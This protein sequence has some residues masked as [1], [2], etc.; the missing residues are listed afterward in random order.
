MDSITST[1]SRFLSLSQ[2]IQLTGL[3]R[4]TIYRRIAVDDFPQP[5]ATGN[6]PNARRI[7][8]ALKDVENWM[9]DRPQAVCARRSQRGAAQFGFVSLVLGAVLL[10]ILGFGAGLFLSDTRPTSRGEHPELVSA[11]AFRASTM[12]VAIAPGK[13]LTSQLGEVQK[14]W[15]ITWPEVRR[16]GAWPLQAVGTPFLSR[17]FQGGVIGFV[18]AGLLPVVIL[19]LILLA[20][21]VMALARQVERFMFPGRT[22]W[23][24]PVR[25]SGRLA[26][27]NFMAVG[28]MG[29]GKSTLLQ[30]LAKH[31]RSLS[32][33]ALIVDYQGEIFSRYFRKSHDVFLSSYDRRSISYSPLAEIHAESDC[34]RVANALVPVSGGSS[35]ERKWA[36]RGRLLVASCLRICFRQ[37]RSGLEVT[38]RSLVQLLNEADAEFFKQNLPESDRLRSV[39]AKDAA[40]FLESVRGVGGFA[41]AAIDGLDPM[42]GFDAFSVRKFVRDSQGTGRW[43]YCVV[44][45]MHEDE[46]FALASFVSAMVVSAKM[47]LGESATRFWMLLDE[48]GQIPA[49]DAI[50]KALSL[51]RKFSLVSAVSFQSIGQLHEHWGEHRSAAIVQGLGNKFLFRSGEPTHLK[52]LVSLVGTEEITRVSTSKSSSFGASPSRSESE[53]SSSR[54]ED[55]VSTSFFK[56]L[57]DWTCV[58]LQ[59]GV[60]GYRAIRVP[61]VDLGRQRF[62]TFVA[63]QN[64]NSAESSRQHSASADDCHNANRDKPDWID[65]DDIVG[66]TSAPSD[67]SSR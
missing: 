53:Q 2:V 31:V 1:T 37:R 33:N 60:T 3:S 44:N 18:S 59:P 35:E 29:A 63:N 10:G 52:W 38:N 7:V 32:E 46:A 39:L 24:G 61:R 51:G 12:V 22:L 11:T 48:F 47:E 45:E 17:W 58:V 49:Q 19:L 13:A 25:V 56:G 65:P 67:N 43:L 23:L 27:R 54:I 62:R 36:Q 40:R 50:P 42:A 8:W 41:L 26:R 4:S 9:S 6:M 34:K 15:K 57:P 28:D 64:D 14:S 20:R 30:T 66:P 16:V 21:W 5:L 55:V